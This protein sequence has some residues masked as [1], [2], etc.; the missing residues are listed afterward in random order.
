MS[1]ENEIACLNFVARA[2]SVG[3]IEKTNCDLKIVRAIFEKVHCNLDSSVF[4]DF[5]FD[6]GLIEHFL[7][8]SSKETRKGSDYKIHEHKSKKE[9]K[10]FFAKHDN[11]FLSMEMRP[12]SFSSYSISSIYENSSYNYFVGSVKRNF[13]NHIE[14]LT[15][16][17]LQHEIVIFLIEQQD[18]RLGVYEKDSFIK[19]YLLSE[20]KN[21]LNYFKNY[22]PL[23]DYV[24]FKS[25]DSVE[26]IDLSLIDEM[27]ECVKENIDIRG[28]RKIDTVVKIYT[29]LW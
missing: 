10:N 22:F 2:L 21:L 20:D 26:I 5:L 3:T 28:G 29:D 24:I 18:G 25:T 17:G 14:S 11:A 13:Y 9:F 12:G 7:V 8:S 6:G 4:P 19:F 23:V 15:K 1:R 16:S 27:I